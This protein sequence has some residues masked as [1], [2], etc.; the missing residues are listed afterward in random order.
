[1][2]SG[3]GND[4][5]EFIDFDEFC[6]FLLASFVLPNSKSWRPVAFYILALNLGS[7]AKI[8]STPASSIRNYGC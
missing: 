7:I 2:E 6:R 4:R 8:I 1:M 5:K 3:L